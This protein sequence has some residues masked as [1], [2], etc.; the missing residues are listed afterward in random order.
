MEQ[1]II[2][3]MGSG[4]CGTQ[5][6]AQVLNQQPGVQVSHEEPPLLPR[7]REPG[8][9]V[10]RER[11]AR[12]RRM[13]NGRV[14]GD[15]ASFY[16]PYV[17][18]AIA[19][20]PSVRVVCLKRPREEVIKSFCNWLDRVHPLPI[21][22]WAENPAP[23]WYHHP[24]WSRVFPQYET[25]DR[26][27]GI[28]RFWD[29]YYDTVSDLV[30]RYPEHVRVFD[31]HRALNTEEGLRELLSFA[32]IPAE[33]QV[34]ALGVRA[35]KMDGQPQE[36]QAR[37]PLAHPM[38]PRRCVILVPFAGQ[39]YPHCERALKELER[40]GYPVR[41]VGGY[42]AID[43]GRNQM[44]TDALLSGFEE[45]MWIDADIDFHPDA[46]DRLRSHNLP[47]V[48]GIYPQKGKRALACHILPGT[49]KIIF[50][51]GGG[52][53]ELKYGATGFLHVRRSVYEK[54][55]RQLQLPMCNERFGS[56]MIPFFQP[57]TCAHDDGYWYLA[58][59][60]AFCE[61]ARRCGF[62]IL[63]DST[64]RLWHVGTYAFG[65]EDA[66]MERERIGTFTLHFPEQIKGGRP[67]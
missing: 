64:V 61:R 25:Q 18:D 16:L 31:T 44:V 49:P 28:G 62:K 24:V 10:I 39:I 42:A 26:E 7:R 37:R 60:Y 19:V 55:Q 57:M 5:S 6:L 32:G 34:L 11:F 8:E 51:Q 58:E 38:D 22:H 12:W 23:G 30:G 35:H 56:P 13:R 54:I 9:R 36:A 4:R 52:L 33:Q 27:E 40:R 41:R 2:L 21:N 59:D 43:Q 63:A 1:S 17:E 45:T 29:D 14:L 48:C 53:V 65:W 3:G 47:I 67:R 15:V 46:I 50:G 20:E 66:G